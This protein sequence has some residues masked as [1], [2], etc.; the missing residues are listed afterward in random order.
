MIK[1]RRPLAAVG[2]EWAAM[3]EVQIRQVRHRGPSIASSSLLGC[4]SAG[5]IGIR[6]DLHGRGEVHLHVGVSGQQRID[7]FG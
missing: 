1:L 2:V 6:V 3:V 7:Q 4:D 5:V